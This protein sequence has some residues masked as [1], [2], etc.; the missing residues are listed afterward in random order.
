MTT[1]SH[2]KTSAEHTKPKHSTKAPPPQVNTPEER[3]K[4][5]IL[6]VLACVVVVLLWIATLPVNFNNEG[7]TTPGPTTFFGRITE[8]L[9]AV[10][11][12]GDLF[13]TVSKAKQ[14]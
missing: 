6:V 14:Q 8:P 10:S 9:G 3:R 4:F 12:I 13:K 5:F 1:A 7:A 11:R 2:K